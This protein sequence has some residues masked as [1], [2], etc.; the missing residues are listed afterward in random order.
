MKMSNL[1]L[2]KIIALIFE[3]ALAVPLIG[4]TIV[5]GTGYAVLG[6]AFFIHLVVF[7]LSLK[8]YGAKLGSILGMVTSVIAWIPVIGWLF[9]AITAIVYAI[10]VLA[11]KE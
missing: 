4:G 9:H 2:A 6:V 5:I 11:K 8:L 7:I 10:E 3:A 1:R